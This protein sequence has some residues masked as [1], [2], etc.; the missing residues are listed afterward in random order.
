MLAK[1]PEKLLN[2]VLKEYPCANPTINQLIQMIHNEVKR[3]EQVAY[4]ISNNNQPWNR[5]LHLLQSLH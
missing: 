5:N 3:L 2:N 1:L 4:I